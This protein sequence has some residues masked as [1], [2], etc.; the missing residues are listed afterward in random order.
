MPALVERRVGLR[1][2]VLLL[3][4]GG[5][6]DDLVGDAAGGDRPVRR[7]DEAVLVHSR[8]GGE[9]A[10]EADVG[11]LRR[12]DRAHAAVV[13]GVHVAD[14]EPGPFA[15]QAA[16][17]EGRQ[18]ALVG[19]AGQGVGLV[20]ELGELAG[21][22]ELLD[23]RDHG[24]DVDQG[25]RRDRL[26]VLGRHP[27]P[28]DALHPG[29]A[30]PDLVL[31]QLAHGA[32]TAVAEVVDVVG[33]QRED[34]LAGD[35]LL[36]ARV[37][38]DQ[39]LDGGD[40]VV[41]AQRALPD[42]Q[43]E[44]ELPVDLVAAHLGQ[45]VP[46]RVE[47]Q[48]LQQRLGRLARRRLT[49]PQLAVDVEQ[50]LVLAGRVVLLQGGAHRLIPAEPVQDLR[51]V[52]AQRLQQHGHAL[53]AL[54]VDADADAVPL[55]DLELQPGPAARDHLAGVD[56]LVAGLVDLPV[57]VDARRADQLADHD[58]L[59]AVDD[60]GALGRHEREVAHEHRLALDLARGVVNELRRHEHRRGV[61]HVLVLAL[62][63][64][65]LG[66][67]EPV[68]T[69]R[70]RHGAREIFDRADLLEDLFEAGLLGYVL[71]A[72]VQCFTDPGLPPLVAEQPVEGLGLEGE[73]IGY[74]ER[75]LDTRERHAA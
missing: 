53:L 5:E 74:L 40:D 6:L 70:E 68:I 39:V 16:G 34:R 43:V 28:D 67:L 30:E 24:P 54:A 75:F 22:E 44:A 58:A 26:D 7:E 29:Q 13:A 12:L 35:H 51:V 33:L 50:R 49:R 10:D 11:A 56:V 2:D 27:L 72:G 62:L 59:G 45:V 38:P 25:L 17:A 32:Q 9:R 8:E 23:G 66:R 20:H 14:L 64:G 71:A 42:R 4:V 31:D 18:A 69:E 19:E 73:E 48:V 47:V 52:P 15:A 63:R 55:V 3:L 65:V 57:E 46:L 60:E 61:R 41:L 36:L 21:A 1:D 37:Q